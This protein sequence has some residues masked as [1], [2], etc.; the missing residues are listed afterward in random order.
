LTLLFLFILVKVNS[1]DEIKNNPLEMFSLIWLDSNPN[2]SQTTEQKLRN[3][4]NQFK[5]FQDIQSCRDFIETTCE[6]DRLILIVSGKLGR[7]LVPNIHQLRQIISIYIFCKNKPINKEWSS[8]Y[9][10]VK[11]VVTNHHDLISRITE[12]HRIE[13]KTEEPLAINIFSVGGKST[14]GLNGKF[15]LIDCLLRLKS[16]DQDKNELIQLLKQQY[17]DNQYELENIDQPKHC[18]GTPKSVFFTKH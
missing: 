8:N 12:D 6:Q 1:V 9:S 15:V 2:E 18:N 3:I 5:K 13:K 7:E 17:N 14:V 16:N 4:I 10:K 11:H